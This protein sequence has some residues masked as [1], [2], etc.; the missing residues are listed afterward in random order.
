MDIVLTKELKVRL[1]RALDK[2][3]IN[4]VEFPEFRDDKHLSNMSY[5]ELNKEV[6]RLQ[7]II[8]EGN[9]GQL[10]EVIAIMQ[11]WAMVLEKGGTLLKLKDD[12]HLMQYLERLQKAVGA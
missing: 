6:L 4:P 10:K 2:G 3:T 1:L 11:E 7:L 8:Y 12:K 5:N 9:L